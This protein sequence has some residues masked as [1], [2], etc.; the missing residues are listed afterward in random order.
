M[1]KTT[2][3]QHELDALFTTSPQTHHAFYDLVLAVMLLHLEQMVAEVQDVEASLLPQQSDDHAAGPVQPITETLPG[4]HK[5]KEQRRV[6]YLFF[7]C[8]LRGYRCVTH[9]TVNSCA[10][11]GMQYTNC[12]A[13]HSLWNS[14]HSSTCITPLLGNGPRHI[15]SSRK[16]RMRDRMTSNMERPQHSLS[17]VSRSPSRAMA[18]C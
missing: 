18:I 14:T 17:L 4:I 16:V 8:K 1:K 9:S 11:T 7:F 12:M 2:T 5:Q 3:N 13:L 10:P 6:L 15:G